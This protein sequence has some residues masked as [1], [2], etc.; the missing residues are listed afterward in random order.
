MILGLCGQA[1]SGKS[2]IA[3]ILQKKYNYKSMSFAD[4]LKRICQDTFKFSDMQ[5]WG[6]SEARN[7]PDL[8]Y[9]R[10]CRGCAGCGYLDDDSQCESCNGAGKTYLT[11]REALQKLGT[12]WGRA[13][14]ENI[15]VKY[16][17]NTAQKLLTNKTGPWLPYSPSK[18][19]GQLPSW[20]EEISGVVISDVR[21]QNEIDGIVNAGGKVVRIKRD[22]TTLKGSAAQHS[23]EVEQSTIPDSA[24]N[25]VLQNVNDL[26]ALTLSIERMMCKLGA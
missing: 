5:L 12:E 15:W 6:P 23:S 25:H 9:P 19:L 11:P 8:R 16:T 4:P 10:P 18:G 17:I 2:F 7:T 1:G 22:T 14:F 24:F 26:D 3:D 20:T 13:C 21:F